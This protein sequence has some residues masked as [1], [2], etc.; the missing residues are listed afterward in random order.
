MQEYEASA[1]ESAD[2]LK[3]DQLAE[4]DDFRENY[5]QTA[6]RYLPSKNLIFLRK[7]EY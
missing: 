4:L 3:A 7:C 5:A 1:F 2:T 6:P